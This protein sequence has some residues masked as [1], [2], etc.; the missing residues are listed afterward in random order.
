MSASWTWP[1]DN[2]VPASWDNEDAPSWLTDGV[3]PHNQ[4][5]IGSCP[6]FS[7]LMPQYIHINLASQDEAIN[8]QKLNLCGNVGDHSTL[9]HDMHVYIDPRSTCIVKNVELHVHSG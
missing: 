3:S 8:I 1:S 9:F 5:A 4:F 6:V 7:L 2:D